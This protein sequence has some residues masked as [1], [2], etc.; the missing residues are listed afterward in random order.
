MR[1]HL[2]QLVWGGRNNQGKLRPDGGS[3]R[4]QVCFQRDLWMT[5]EA[6]AQEWDL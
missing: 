4:R 3:F 2:D 1:D 6:S 5:V